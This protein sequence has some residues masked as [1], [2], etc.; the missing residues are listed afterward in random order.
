MRVPD[1]VR[2]ADKDLMG[3]YG[4]VVD[5][6]CAVNIS[7]DIEWKRGL[8]GY[9]GLVFV[10]LTTVVGTRAGMVVRIQV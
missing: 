7:V 1:V 9:H 6:P 10:R 2:Q 5:D 8:I 4:D 3:Q